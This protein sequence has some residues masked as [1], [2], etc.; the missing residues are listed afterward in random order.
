MERF[1]SLQEGKPPP[2]TSGDHFIA[3]ALKLL[4]YYELS[5][6]SKNQHGLGL[7]SLGSQEINQYQQSSMS[8]FSLDFS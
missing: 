8:V 2:K 5:T 6:D 4:F 1:P 3:K 7:D